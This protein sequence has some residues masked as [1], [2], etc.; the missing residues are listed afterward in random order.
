MT[1]GIGTHNHNYKNHH[2]VKHELEMIRNKVRVAF[3]SCRIID[4]LLQRPPPFFARYLSTS[5]IDFAQI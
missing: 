4:V 5:L 3:Q 1:L 2:R